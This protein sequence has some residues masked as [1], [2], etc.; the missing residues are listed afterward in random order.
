MRSSRIERI[1]LL[2]TGE[3]RDSSSVRCA[4]LAGSRGGIN[5][6]LQGSA[7]N[8]FAYTHRF[9]LRRRFLSGGTNSST[10][11]RVDHDTDEI[12][13]DDGEL[14]Q[15]GRISGHGRKAISA[16]GASPRRFHLWPP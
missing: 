7:A 3:N 12:D 16:R 10:V 5:A 11:E 1:C 15:I 4:R 13:M 6:F 9:P 14:W 8:D 2:I